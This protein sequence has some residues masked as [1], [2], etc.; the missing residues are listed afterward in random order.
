VRGDGQVGEPQYRC[1]SLLGQQVAEGREE[2]SKPRGRFPS[3]RNPSGVLQHLAVR[4][5]GWGGV[6]VLYP[7]HWRL[8]TEQIFHG[9]PPMSRAQPP[10]PCCRHAQI[11]S[12]AWAA[13]RGAPLRAGARAY[14]WSAGSSESNHSACVELIDASRASHRMTE[15]SMPAEY[16]ITGRSIRL[17]HGSAHPNEP[18]SPDACLAA[19]R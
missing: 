16:T 6:E 7:C 19:L 11:S 17:P 2:S 1:G 18:R 5:P 4:R 13:A 3:R 8:L 14:L 9:L 15:L 10:F 12:T